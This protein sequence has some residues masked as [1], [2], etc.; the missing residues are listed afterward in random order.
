MIQVKIFF[1]VDDCNKWL[2]DNQDMQIL[3]Y[4]SSGPKYFF[5][6]YEFKVKE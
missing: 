6:V 5:I 2:E 4:Y 1:N 3:K